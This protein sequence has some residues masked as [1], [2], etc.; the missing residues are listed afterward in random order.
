MS[1][2]IL[3]YVTGND[4]FA[5]DAVPMFGYVALGDSPDLQAEPIPAGSL[6]EI[7]GD[8]AVRPANPDSIAVIGVTSEP[9]Q[10]HGAGLVYFSGVHPLIVEDEVFAGERVSP[11]KDGTVRP[12]VANSIGI[13]LRSGKSGERIDV[14]LTI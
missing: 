7:V 5:G 14:L 4:V 1:N 2:A 3:Q 10:C 13:A 6:V 8:R 11:G 9:I 12:G